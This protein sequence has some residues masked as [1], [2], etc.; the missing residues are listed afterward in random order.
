M[1]NTVSELYRWGFSRGLAQTLDGIDAD[2][3]HIVQA[4]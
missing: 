1:K 3:S 4:L 2:T